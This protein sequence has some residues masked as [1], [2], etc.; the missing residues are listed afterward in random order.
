M[1]YKTS[2]QGSKRTQ[3]LSILRAKKNVSGEKLAQELNISRVAVWKHIQVLQEAGY[4]I[5]SSKTGYTLI[6][7]ALNSIKPW[8]FGERETK[9]R[10]VAE[11]SSTMDSAR[12]AALTMSP[13]GTLV[14]AEKQSAGK[15]TNGKTWESARGGIF[16]TLIT[17][18]KLQAS[19][20][21]RLCL[22]AQCALA[23]SITELSGENAWLG[24]PNDIYTKKGKIAGV[25][26]E[27]FTQGNQ[28]NFV[29][30]GFGVNTGTKPSLDNSACVSVQRKEL[31]QNF[32][33]RFEVLSIQDTTLVARWEGL[34]PYIQAQIEAKLVHL[35][36]SLSQESVSG[37]FLG[38]NPLGNLVIKDTEGKTTNFAP[39]MLYALHKH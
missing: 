19:Y 3:L 32:L 8:E 15:G 35:D 29:N 33:D 31:V 22:A 10:Y 28:L 30:I 25:L 37:I 13:E 1:V 20:V 26:L 5:E 23:E 7:D 12:E 14:I 21:H 6:A 36:G 34:C 24:W 11:T 39:G 16:A 4:K 27:S 18:P 17:R 9:I 38:L 2:P